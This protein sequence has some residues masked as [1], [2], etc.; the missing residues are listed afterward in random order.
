MKNSEEW[1][2]Y[3]PLGAAIAGLPYIDLTSSDEVEIKQKHREI[4]DSINEKVSIS[5]CL[6]Y[7]KNFVSHRPVVFFIFVGVD[8]GKN[9][10]KVCRI[11]NVV[12]RMIDDE[13]ILLVM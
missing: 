13:W 6:K 2:E 11:K 8:R 4:L 12:A 5:A 1:R 3:S 7:I 10:G 9:F